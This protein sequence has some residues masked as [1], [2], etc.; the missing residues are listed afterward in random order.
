MDPAPVQHKLE[1]TRKRPGL[2]RCP[3]LDGSTSL[4]ALLYPMI[5]FSLSKTSALCPL[6]LQIAQ[7][8]LIFPRWV[9]MGLTLPRI[10]P[11]TPV[12]TQQSQKICMYTKHPQPHP[13][14]PFS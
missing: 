8:A 12:H 3:D 1:K 10:P 6:C 4:R 11:P 5:E 7:M 13:K 2:A 14:H 9:T